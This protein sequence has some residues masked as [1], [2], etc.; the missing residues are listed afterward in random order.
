MIVD[1]TGMIR[2][3]YKDDSEKSLGT[4]IEDLAVILP[5]KKA[6]DIVIKNQEQ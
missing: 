6:K 2:Q 1:T 5:R 4:M 3:F